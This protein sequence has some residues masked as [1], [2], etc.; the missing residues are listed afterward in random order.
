MTPHL[1]EEIWAALGGEGL[2]AQAPW[3]AADPAYL[4][5]RTM[6]QLTAPMTPHLAEEIWAALGGEGLVAQAPWPAADPAYL[7]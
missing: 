3:P 6:A 4:A 7:A 1:A 2:V 5:L